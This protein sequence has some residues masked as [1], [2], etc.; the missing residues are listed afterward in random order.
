MFTAYRLL[1]V[2]GDRFTVVAAEGASMQ[3]EIAQPFTQKP[4]VVV[5]PAN[6]LIGNSA[7]MR[8]V[9]AL[10]A[11]LANSKSTVLITGES[12]TGKELAARAIHESSPR[13]GES[14]VPVNC[15]AIPEELL[16]SEL[17]GHVRGAFTGAVNARQGRFQLA[18]GGTLF[19]DEIGEM[20]PKLQ[21][22]LLRVLQERQFE[23]VGSDHTVQ[24][25]VRV[26]AATNRDLQVAVREGRFREDLFYRLNVL[27]LELPS[28]RAREG[29]TA[30]LIRHFLKLHGRRKGKPILEVD[31]A[32]M[33]LLERYD[34]PGNVREVENLVERLVV[35]NEDGV[36]RA[37]D[38]PD[39]VATNSVPHH[40]KTAEVSL[41]HQG[42]DLDGFLERIENGF[43]QQALERSR[44]N[45]TLAAELLKLNRTT[46]I[47]RLRKKGMLQPVRRPSLP[48]EAVGKM[49]D[50]SI[51]L[52]ASD[53]NLWNP[54][55]FAYADGEK[56]ANVSS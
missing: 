19:L 36:I 48:A 31:P 10:I 20:S 14:F 6:P 15:G 26:V 16:E 13:R 21:V 8:V 39:Y 23:P 41:P 5:A 45:K 50:N 11:K 40:Q 38:L 32:A 30:L 3:L 46:F 27:P 43:I 37:G 56:I 44:G 34:W 18:N 47:E 22:K 1:Q 49:T 42:V 54:S 25:D 29:D 51:S 33:A 35:L 52:T 53:S 7:R 17:F 12:G 55:A 9:H 2:A 28:L 4:H 24:V